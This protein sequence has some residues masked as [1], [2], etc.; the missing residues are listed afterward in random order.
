V[1]THGGQRW[2]GF[3]QVYLHGQAMAMHDIVSIHAGDE[4]ATA[5]GPSGVERFDQTMRGRLDEAKTRIELCEA[6][7]TIYRIIK[8]TVIDNDTLPVGFALPLNAA[9]T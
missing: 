3:Q 1:A 6:A 5:I 7:S 8:R 2:I 9:Q 4:G